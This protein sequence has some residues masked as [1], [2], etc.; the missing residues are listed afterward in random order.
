MVIDRNK[1]Q[2]MALILAMF[3][4]VLVTTIVVSVSWRFQLSMARNENRWHGAQARAYLE[5]SEQLARKV[6]I[7]DAKEGP[8]DHLAE[9]WTQT[10]EPL[11]TDEGWIRGKIE[12][13]HSRFNLNLLVAPPIDPKKPPKSEL[14]KYTA[15]QRRFI[16]F[17]MM[18]E[19]EEG[20]QMDVATATG[21]V[22]AIQDW[23]DPNNDPSGYEGAEKDHYESLDPPV[24]IPNGPM[25]SVSELLL[26]K[27]VTPEIYEQLLPYI[28]ALDSS[29]KMNI[30]T[31][32]PI[33]MRTFNRKEL[34]EPLAEAD[35]QSL[36]QER[37]LAE[38]GFTEV[39]TFAE[40]PVI[41][42]I[43]GDANEFDTKDFTV[44][45]SYFLFFAET[46]VGEQVRR[47]KSILFRTGMDVQVVRR[48][49]ANF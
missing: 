24:L 27:G 33:I 38:F 29:V 41:Q 22:D 25:T 19:F 35:W 48:T 17:L 8:T 18:L 6:L 49:D 40:N 45:S 30:N 9:M 43:V 2:G 37:G 23:L 26:V 39:N 42:G 34:L 32:S 46:L 16:R 15:M 5:G 3:I 31:V 14:D 36:V 47:S 12:D 13:A 7:E 44:Q 21:I 28:I 1:Q 4:V 10:G 20:Q 11:P